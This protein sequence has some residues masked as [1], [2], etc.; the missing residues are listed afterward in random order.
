[1]SLSVSLRR[2]SIL[3][4]IARGGMPAGPNVPKIVLLIMGDHQKSDMVYFGLPA[5]GIHEPYKP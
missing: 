5:V 1:M 2:L 3:H 4:E